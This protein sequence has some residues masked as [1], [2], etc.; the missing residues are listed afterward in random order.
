MEAA[1]VYS[2]LF[3]ALLA[4]VEFGLGFKEWITCPTQPL[5]GPVPVPRLNLTATPR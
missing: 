5:R 1:V 3:L 2:L 4:L